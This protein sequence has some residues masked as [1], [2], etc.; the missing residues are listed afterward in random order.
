MRN[1]GKSII[2]EGYLSDLV[3]MSDDEL[4]GGRFGLIELEI[5]M[6]PRMMRDV[7]IWSDVLS[8][9]GRYVEY[10]LLVVIACR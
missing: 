4:T 10:T 9:P 6:V 5:G 2:I 8:V 3:V 1:S 7:V